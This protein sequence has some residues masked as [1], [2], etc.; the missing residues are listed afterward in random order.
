MK[1]WSFNCLA[2]IVYWVFVSQIAQAQSPGLRFNQIWITTSQ[3]DCLARARQGLA[4]G[5]YQITG[6]GDW[7]VASTNLTTRTAVCVSCLTVGSQTQA[8]V[9][10]AGASDPQASQ[11]VDYLVRYMAGQGSTLPANTAVRGQVSPI[12][13]RFNQAWVTLSQSDCLA[14]ARQGLANGQYQIT[15]QGDW[16]VASTN[17]TTRTTICV[18]CLTVG[19]QTQ[20]FVSA[21]SP[22]DPSATQWV[23]YLLKYVASGQVVTNPAQPPT[24]NAGGCLRSTTYGLTIVPN[25]A[26]V[27]QTV[28]IRYMYPGDKP[29]G[30][31]WIGCF[32]PNTKQS[33]TG[34]WTYL[35]KVTSCEYDFVVPSINPGPMQFRYILEG[36][37]DKI[38]AT[39]EFVVLP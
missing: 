6:Q 22:S 15:A 20:A 8:Y 2:V 36:G 28:K 27:G 38:T 24:N 32:Y 26:R 13:L 5:Q 31:D 17:V 29:G 39:A 34:F 21:A 16:W 9:S 35:T 1:G 23:D 14:K 3:S 19:S 10:A 11:W 30:G 25:S 12:T 7:W 37:Y 33:Y 18:S 4:N